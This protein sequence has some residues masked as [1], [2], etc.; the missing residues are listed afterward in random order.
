V[1]DEFIGMG[2]KGKNRI[3]Q[4][5]NVLEQSSVEMVFGIQCRAD[6]VDSHLFSRLKEVGLQHV[7]IGV[8]S[9]IP[10]QLAL[11]NKKIETKKNLH[12]LK[13]LEKIGIEYNIGLILYDPYSSLEEIQE[14]VDFLRLASGFP[15][16]LNGLNVLNGTALYTQLDADG[17]LEKLEG[18]TNY[19]FFNPVL[20]T[21]RKSVRAY[22]D[23]Y[24][25]II[26]RLRKLSGIFVTQLGN[27]Y[28]SKIILDSWYQKI[29]EF[30]IYFLD[31]TIA[32]LKSGESVNSLLSN[33][34]S[35]YYRL[36]LEIDQ[37][38]KTISNFSQ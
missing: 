38:L 3:Y 8:E 4:F 29:R 27:P 28:Q 2:E 21:F 18:D 5:C 1:D 37:Y 30:H 31:N 33:L 24:I 16:G 12:A 35:E 26:N 32:L 10:R 13:L 7:Y 14:T 25:P 15:L 36:D 20:E 17:L 19:R 6:S 22:A 11:F 34:E 9:V 23:I